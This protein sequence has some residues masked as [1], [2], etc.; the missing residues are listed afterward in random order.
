MTGSTVL[1][2][3]TGNRRYYDV[4]EVH[5][6]RC[7][8]DPLWFV[9]LKRLRPGRLD[10][11]KSAG[12][13]ALFASNHERRSSL[14][15]TLP[16]VRALGLFTNRHE[17]EIRDQRL[18]RPECRIVGKPHPDPVWLFIPVQTWIHQHP[19]PTIKTTSAHC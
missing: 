3:I 11:A 10:C 2:I 8:S 14:T 4:V 6:L 15:P 9:Y 5:S 17:L 1:Q 13:S 7:L 12:T 19:W 16:P 18:G